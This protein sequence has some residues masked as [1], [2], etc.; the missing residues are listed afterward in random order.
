MGQ[1]AALDSLWLTR[2]K[3][4]LEKCSQ[5]GLLVHNARFHGIRIEITLLL[6]VE[7]NCSG[8]HEANFKAREHL[9]P[10]GGRAA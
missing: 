10:S 5:I 1:L 8:K 6:P 7:G 3:C 2:Y 4:R 9:P